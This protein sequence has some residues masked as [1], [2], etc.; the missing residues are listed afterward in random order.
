MDIAARNLRLPLALGSSRQ[1]VRAAH[2][3]GGR[4]LEVSPAADSAAFAGAMPIAT[5]CFPPMHVDLMLFVSTT[6][7]G[8]PDN[9]LEE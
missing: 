7:V 9:F 6:F 5:T 2:L 4:R 3:L 1:R 8:V